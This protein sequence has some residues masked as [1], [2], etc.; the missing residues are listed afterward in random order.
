MGTSEKDLGKCVWICVIQNRVLANLIPELRSSGL[1]LGHG[2]SLQPNASSSGVSRNENF[3]ATREV[4]V[5][6]PTPQ[7]HFLSKKD[8]TN[9]ACYFFGIRDSST[10]WCYDP[11]KWL[12]LTDPKFFQSWNIEENTTHHTELSWAASKIMLP[13]TQD[14]RTGH[15]STDRIQYSIFTPWPLWG[16]GYATKNK[17]SKDDN[18]KCNNYLQLWFFLNQKAF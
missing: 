9:S 11:R 6:R 18:S 5:F 4:L 10:C 17:D 7:P 12:D 15:T 13:N 2:G 16:F 3:R 14:A 8:V 1:A